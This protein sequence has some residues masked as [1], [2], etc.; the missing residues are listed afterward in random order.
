MSDRIESISIS[1]ALVTPAA[2]RAL[3]RAL[4]TM[5]DSWDYKLPTEES[6]TQR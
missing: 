6:R 3:L 4:T 1:S 5:D 2:M